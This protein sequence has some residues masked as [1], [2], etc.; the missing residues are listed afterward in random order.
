MEAIPGLGGGE[1]LIIAIVIGS[2]LISVVVAIV[3]VLF[4]VKLIKGLGDAAAA[5][6]KILQ[7]GR[8]ADAKILQ[9]GAGGMT[10]SQG[11]QR[12]VQ[13]TLVLEI[14]LQDRSMNPYQVS[15][16]PLVPEI[17]FARL[18]P[19]SSIPVKV[20]AANPQSIAIDFPAMGYMV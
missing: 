4:V 1:V 2:I 11:A 14:H 7:T 18:Q 3:S 16:S 15:L 5:N 20:D 8:P 13:V 12:S 6:R 9:V 19:G 17:A 10:V